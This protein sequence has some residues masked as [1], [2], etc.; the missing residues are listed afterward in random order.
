M[1]GDWIKMRVAIRRSAK[2][3]AV[4][5]QLEAQPAFR[6]WL[7]V[8]N[9][10]SHRVTTRVTVCGLLE[11]WGAVNEAIS[12][13]ETVSFMSVCD[14]DNV[15]DIPG[16]GRA[17]LAVGWIEELPDSAGLKFPNF[18]EYNTPEAERQKPKTGAERT[19]EWRARQR[20]KEKCDE[21]VTAGDACDAREEKRRVKKNPPN[22][23]AKP[24]GLLSENTGGQEVTN[25]AAY[26]TERLPQAIVS[27]RDRERIAAALAAGYQ[28][29]QVCLGIDGYLA[30]APKTPTL[31]AALRD[32]GTVGGWI[33]AALSRPQKATL[34]T[35]DREKEAARGR[36]IR[37]ELQTRGHEARDEIEAEAAVRFDAGAVKQSCKRAQEG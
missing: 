20:A 7:G 6:R 3:V 27:D 34:N 24:G 25:V 1:A 28:D 16:F 18:H 4:A 30:S 15:T 5:R 35:P 32:T 26:W 23:P 37:Q 14:V 8:T 10:P 33:S 9:T 17:M 12:P 19:R 21:T 31:R 36:W 2:T 29:H 22:P 11:L 13:E